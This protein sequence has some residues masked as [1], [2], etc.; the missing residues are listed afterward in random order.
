MNTLHN[1]SNASR[2]NV[3]GKISRL[4]DL[5]QLGMP[6]KPGL[7]L[8]GDDISQIRVAG[9]N[10]PM[11]T[12]VLAD[13]NVDQNGL[14]VR[15]SATDEDGERS[16]AGQFVTKLFVGKDDLQSAIMCCIDA[17]DSE[18]VA[19]YATANNVPVPRLALLIQ[20]MVPAVMAGVLFT[21]DPLGRI[22]GMII[23]VVEGVAEDLVSGTRTPRCYHI[24]FSGDVPIINVTGSV[25]P[26][27]SLELLRQLW[28]I[29]LKLEENFGCPQDIEW[30]V[31]GAGQLFVNQ[32]RDIT[33]QVA[34]LESIRRQAIA[35][36]RASFGAEQERLATL[37]V[38][39]EG[40]VYTDQNVAEI[41]GVHPCRM[42]FGMFT[43][44]FAHG[45]G[46][47]R[48]GR[49]SMGYEIGAELEQG[50][51]V[52]IGGQPRVSIAHD[53]MTYRVAGI[54]IGQYTQA[55]SHYLSCIAEDPRRA[56]YPEIG[57]YEQS[58]SADWLQTIYGEESAVT[59]QCYREFHAAFGAIYE[60]LD[61]ETVRDWRPA[62]RVRVT[63][64]ERLF[65][66]G[67]QSDVD[68]L[69]LVFTALREDACRRFVLVT[70]VGFFAYDQL[71][72]TLQRL[73]AERAKEYAGTLTSGIPMAINPNL[74]FGTALWDLK[75]GNRDLASVMQ[76]FGHLGI[77]ELDVVQPR[78]HERPHIV[79]QTA[80]RFTHDP[81]EELEAAVHRAMDLRGTLLA[82]LPA[83]AASELNHQIELAR[84]YLPLREVVKFEYLRGFDLARQ[85]MIAIGHRRGWSEDL[86]FH[87]DPLDLL[88]DESEMLHAVAKSR[89]EQWNAYRQLSVPAVI[90][91]GD[92]EMI[93]RTPEPS[94]D[95]VLHGIGVSN[96]IT[97][98][99]V[100]IVESPQDSQAIERLHAGCIV[101]TQTTDP[102]WTPVLSIIGQQGGLVTEVGGQLAHGAIYC[103][104]MGIAAVLN[105]PDAR[106]R[107]RNGMRVRVNGQQGTVE[108]L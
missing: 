61:I 23:E 94:G 79:E 31:D 1:L 91:T 56:N 2:N 7:V 15:S 69:R 22:M 16:W 76:E 68:C 90:F 35:E 32:C 38:K 89:R 87:L 85:I 88:G 41:L 29:G 82:S 67:E 78:Y 52:L 6:V 26:E 75:L 45:E 95:G 13:L 19:A 55:V 60:A 66:S 40:D 59:S 4:H 18:T 42:T 104:E 58:P 62:W 49:C 54:P 65:A 24:D 101:V 25:G 8:D 10:L 80:Q 53:S 99:E 63:E 34:D 17:V 36:T 3:G 105:V 84:R 106:A 86:I 28:E 83:Q 96:Y 27:M 102:A 50:F 12:D 108:I 47:I 93:G 98:G 97:E 48:T 70:R 71:Q 73:F 33:T 81:R 43:H 14:A 57:L 30:A 103:R 44:L 64:L 39:L 20:E 5:I 51:F 77:H 100:V 107:L 92:F 9:I 72:R 11:I 46:A 37:G 74:Q 21:D